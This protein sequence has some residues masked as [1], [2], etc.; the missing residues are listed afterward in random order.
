MTTTT[1]HPK[2]TLDTHRVT[3]EPIITI[4]F[5][6]KHSVIVY[7]HTFPA[8]HVTVMSM[9]DVPVLALDMSDTVESG[10]G[11]G[12][13]SVGQNSKGGTT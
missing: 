11:P 6:G 13:E 8:D 2:I 1:A 4:E 3:G 9:G 12:S 7:P 10:S 5:P